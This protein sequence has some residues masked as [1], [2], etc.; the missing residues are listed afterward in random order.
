MNGQRSK[1]AFDVYAYELMVK[2]HMQYTPHKFRLLLT[3]SLVVDELPIYLK[4]ADEQYE[5]SI[6]FFCTACSK[7]HFSK[8]IFSKLVVEKNGRNL[9]WLNCGHLR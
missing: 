7:R 6:L 5:D 2:N 8:L 3:I 4:T 9:K 1:Y